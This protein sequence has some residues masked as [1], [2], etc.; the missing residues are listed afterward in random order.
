MRAWTF[1]HDRFRQPRAA[2][3]DLGEKDGPRGC[4]APVVVPRAQASPRTSQICVRNRTRF[5]HTARLLRHTVSIRNLDPI[6]GLCW[7]LS[8]ASATPAILGRFLRTRGANGCRRCDFSLQR[9]RFISTLQFVARQHGGGS[10]N[11]SW[12]ACSH[13][14]YRDGRTSTKGPH[15]RPSRP[16]RASQMW[17]DLRRPPRGPGRHSLLGEERKTGLTPDGGDAL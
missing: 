11:L 13:A 15:D 1:E 16:G 7:L 10:L 5:R 2:S 4:V 12:A 14:Q 17:T 6:A 9:M 8:S 3:S